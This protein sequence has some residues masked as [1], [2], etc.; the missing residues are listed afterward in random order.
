MHLQFFRKK[1]FYSRPEFW[2]YF[3]FL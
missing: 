3:L 2:N 1:G